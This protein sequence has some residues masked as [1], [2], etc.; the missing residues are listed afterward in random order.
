MNKPSVENSALQNA[1][2]DALRFAKSHYENFPVVSLFLPKKLRKHVAVVYKFARQADDFADEGTLTQIQ[3]L[4]LLNEYEQQ[5]EK[6]LQGNYKNGFWE[7]LHNTVRDF[8]LSSHNFFDLLSAFKQDVVKKR[9]QSH[10]EVLDYC[11]RSAN[12]VGRIILEFFN[13]R[14]DESKL[15]SD[16]ICT[17]LQLTN[18]CQDVSIDIQKDRI[19]IPLDEIHDFNVDPDQF[20]TK[21]INADF[22]KLLKYQVERTHK[23]FR[24]GRKL[25]PRLPKDLKPQIKMTILGGEKILDKIA[26]LDYDVLNSRPKLS[27]L[28]YTGIFLKAIIY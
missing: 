2:F 23:L 3:R 13:I 12:P 22:R 25:I 28:D 15:Y 4:Q 9:Y 11:K 14:D 21:E 5:L 17:A 26:S 8:N 7:V 6:S 27:G 16:A 20:R 1:Y 19:Y 10:Q 18:F 24:T